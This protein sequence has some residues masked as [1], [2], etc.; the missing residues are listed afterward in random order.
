ML[1][2]RFVESPGPSELGRQKAL[3]DTNVWLSLVIDR[4]NV[5]FLPWIRLT[6]RTA[7]RLPAF[8]G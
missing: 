5:I 7:T 3:L 8:A 6:K 1:S 2:A 4:T